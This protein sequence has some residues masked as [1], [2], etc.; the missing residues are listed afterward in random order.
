MRPTAITLCCA[1][2]LTGRAARPY[3]LAIGAETA[4][5]GPETQFA[6]PERTSSKGRA[7]S[8]ARADREPELVNDL[9]ARLGQSAAQTLTFRD[10][11]DGE[12]ITSQFIFVRVRAAHAIKGQHD[13]PR[14]EW[15]IAEW[16]DGHDQPLDYWISNLPAKSPHEHMATLARLRWMIEL[17]YRQIKGHLGLDHYEGRSWL[18]W[19]HHTALVTAAHGF[20]TLERQHPNHQRPA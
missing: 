6:V 11:P 13:A 1:S 16:P 7:A 12:P 4:V 18:G 3:V 17:D 8:K 19:Y 14:E 15:L 20:L 5:Y 9:I 10:G 2:A